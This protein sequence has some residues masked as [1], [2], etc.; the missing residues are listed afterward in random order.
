MELGL[1]EKIT[2]FFH[3]TPYLEVIKFAKGEGKLQLVA[4]TELHQRE[5]ECDDATKAQSILQSNKFAKGE[6]NFQLVAKMELHQRGI[7]CDDATKAQNIL[8]S[9]KFAKGEGNLQLAAKTKLRQRGIMC[10]DAN[11]A[12]SIL[13]SINNPK[14]NPTSR[15]KCA[16]AKIGAL[17][18]NDKEDKWSP[19]EEIQLR[20][21]CKAQYSILKIAEIMKCDVTSKRTVHNNIL[22][23]QIQVKFKGKYQLLTKKYN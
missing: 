21:L 15:A 19:G 11:K 16:A 22:E 4:K 18:V 12:L 8:Q 20:E 1:L 3:R 23:L 7:E 2:I 17:N 10:D 14:K 9:A 5:I 6:G 13:S